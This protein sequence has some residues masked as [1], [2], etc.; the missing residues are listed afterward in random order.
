MDVESGVREFLQE[1]VPGGQARGI[2]SHESLLDS[3]ILDSATILE[4]VSFL[5]ERYSLT[6]SDEELVPENFETI[7]AIAGIV[8]SK[9]GPAAAGGD[10]SR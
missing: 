7:D 5:E 3:G 4:L 10:T 9:R 6:I 8:A 1:H 2:P